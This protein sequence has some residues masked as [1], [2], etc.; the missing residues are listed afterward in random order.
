MGIV[1]DY[2]GLLIARIF[3]GVAGK[4]IGVGCTPYSLHEINGKRLTSANRG[5][6]I[7]W[8]CI[9]YHYVVLQ[10]RGAA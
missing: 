5:W 9:L 10:T 1:Q 8:G 7:P 2:K 6:I 3:L 4:H